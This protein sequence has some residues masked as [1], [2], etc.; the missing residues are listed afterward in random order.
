MEHQQLGEHA[1]DLLLPCLTLKEKDG[2][3]LITFDDKD[4][5]VNT[6]NSKLTPQFEEVLDYVEKSSTI[7]ALVLISGKKSCFIA[8]AD[9]AELQAAKNEAEVK[10]LSQ[11]GQEFFKRLSKLK[12]P[13]VAAI[14]GS[15]LGGGLELALACDY[16]VAT[17]AG[18]TVLGLPEV[19]LGLLPGA[20]GT[21]RL[22]ALIGLEKAL[23]MMLTGSNVKAEKAKKIG[24]V[25]YVVHPGGL[26]AKAVEVAKA[27]GEGKLKVNRKRKTTAASMLQSV[28]AGKRFILQK[29]LQ[30]VESKT[31]GL[32]PAP[33]GI[34]EVLNYS[35]DHP[36]KGYLKE[37]EVFARLSQTPESKGLIS[38]YFGQTDLKKNRYGSPKKPA[39]NL[40]VLGAGLM[41]A[42]IAMI[43]LQKDF[44]IRLR[45]IG[46]D[47]IANGKKYI[48]SN[49][50]KRVKR[51]SLSRFDAQK[52]MSR[53]FAQTDYKHFN[54]CDMVIE[55]VFE[56][57]E[58]KH[59]VLKEVEE[60]ASEDMIF[61]SNTS[62]LPISD[63]AKASKRPERVIGM[64][65]FSP[66]HKMPLLEV[67]VTEQTTDD[68]A[69]AAVDV[70]IRQGKTVIV[71][72]DGPGFYTT[73]ILAPYM[74]EVAILAAEGVDF[75]TLDDAMMDFGYPV[76]PIA[77]VDE[78]GIDVGYHV[79][80]SLGKA[81]GKRVSSGDLQILTELVAKGA[82]GRK[83]GK[84]FYLYKNQKKN[85]LDR[86]IGKKSSKKP[87][88]P[89]VIEL[90][91]KLGKK[92]SK[93][94]DL[95]DVQKRMYL[96]MIN[97]AAY[98]LH[99]GILKRPLDGDIGAVFG[100]GFPPFHGGPFR[101]VDKVGAKKIVDDLK[102]YEDSL[103][104]RFSPA[105]NLVEM[106][107]SGAKFYSE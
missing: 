98:C 2:V 65:Y 10:K 92:T 88:N 62:A 64:H 80:E 58:L 9:I 12:Q 49:L 36:D 95:E 35:V 105:P 16:R 42:G 34:I 101:F 46:Y 84:G 97:E 14:N 41:G 30:Q 63:I 5:K 57:L 78:V 96:R 23:P 60:C 89:E 50:D 39:Q 68:V 38:L 76:G 87:I 29:A 103:G 67:I 77:L 107:N 15:C 79:S 48:W 32:Y 24:L 43:S 4:A 100:L 91:N 45:D 85:L 37:S 75:Y 71:V 40:G 22:P 72:G 52:V 7:K 104:E 81:F 94:I 6:L 11:S 44:H 66:V 26:Q 19:M 18:N 28:K 33:K 8:G 74:D 90:I 69:A 55:A 20:G 53:L 54:E 61:A 99:D 47:Q 31:R 83:S 93:P 59:R 102:R 70:G 73:R 3:A 13:V 51:R 86:F 56:D 1:A 106:A 25:D 27:M 82:K 21:Q 17:S